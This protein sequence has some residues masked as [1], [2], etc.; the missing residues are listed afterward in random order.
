MFSQELRIAITTIAQNINATLSVLL[1]KLPGTTNG[2]WFAQYT[3]FVN[4]NF[5][6]DSSSTYSEAIPRGPS[7]F[8]GLRCRLRRCQPRRHHGP[9]LR[10]RKIP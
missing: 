8:L 2:N 9:S 1:A 7:G 6:L 3:S 4:G 5:T 10:W